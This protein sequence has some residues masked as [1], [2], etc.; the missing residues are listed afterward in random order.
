MGPPPRF[1]DGNFFDLPDKNTITKSQWLKE[2]GPTLGYYIGSRPFILTSDT[3]LIK[4]ILVKDFHF[5]SQR[6]MLGIVGGFEAS[7]DMEQAL[8]HPEVDAKRWKEQR[9][10]I[11]KGKYFQGF[12][13]TVRNP[14]SKMIES[15]KE[16]I[17]SLFCSLFFGETENF[18]SSRE[19]CH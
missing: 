15:V 1:L 11:T 18:G 5:F 7:P 2:Y 19:R 17:F 9:S 4:R 10:L 16:S 13:S 3:E 6:P 14:L 12:L 8:I